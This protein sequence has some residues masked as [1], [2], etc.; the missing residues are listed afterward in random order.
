[1]RKSFY[2]SSLLFFCFFLSS[3]TLMAQSSTPGAPVITSNPKNDT[4]CSGSTAWFAITAND[5]LGG[6]TMTIHYTWEVSADGGATWD[7]VHNTAP[8][9]G[10]K[11]DTLRI[12]AAN[13]LNGYWYMCGATTDSGSTWS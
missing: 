10:A 4:V 12:H 5:T 6:D 2:L 9:S 1:M 7:T 3:A 13:Y 11:T 8:Y